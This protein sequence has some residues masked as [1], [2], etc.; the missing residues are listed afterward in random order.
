MN[1]KKRNAQLNKFIF[2]VIIITIFLIITRIIFNIFEFPEVLEILRDVD[3]YMR[4][5]EVNNGLFEFYNPDK[6]FPAVY[7]YYWYF[8]FLPMSVIP[9]EIGLYIWDGLRLISTIYVMKNVPKI[10]DNQRDLFIFY[11]GTLF[12]Y[13]LDGY[14]NNC[15]F[16]IQLLLLESYF[17]WEKEKKWI[18]GILF[19]LAL[20]KINVIIYLPILGLIKKLRVK[21][22]IYYLLPIGLLSIVYIIFPNFFLQMITNWMNFEGQEPVVFTPFSFIIIF[23]LI[24]WQAL[25]PAQLMYFCLIIIIISEYFQDI[26]KRNRFRNFVVIGLTSYYTLEIILL[27]LFPPV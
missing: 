24:T 23:N 12:G 18:A 20:Y 25:Q 13:F 15:N 5:E 7:L 26:K 22:L 21:D 14:F 4:L 3:Y 11:G 8:M 16:I 19:T 2:L 27:I 1:N 6:D 9:T 17:S 10:T